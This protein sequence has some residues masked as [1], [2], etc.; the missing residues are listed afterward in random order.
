MGNE[1]DNDNGRADRMATYLW[2]G[3]ERYWVMLLRDGR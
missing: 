3:C 2:Y 1:I